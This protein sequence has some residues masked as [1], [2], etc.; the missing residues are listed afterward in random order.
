MHSEVSLDFVRVTV[1]EKHWPFSVPLFLCPICM[2]QF[3]ALQGVYRNLCEPQ[4]EPSSGPKAVFLTG[5]F[6]SGRKQRCLSHRMHSGVGKGPG[7][8]RA[9]KLK[10]TKCFLYFCL[11]QQCKFQDT[12]DLDSV[13]A[14]V[15]SELRRVRSYGSRKSW[16]K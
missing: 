13:V 2:G 1:K 6:D 8:N 11:N 16:E 3:P 9:S 7:G 5:G 10:I 15:G 12:L 14:G 4:S